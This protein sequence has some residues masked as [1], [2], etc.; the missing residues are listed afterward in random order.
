MLH[1]WKIPQARATMDIDL[2]GKLDNSVAYVEECIK[3][4]LQISTPD[5]GLTFDPDSVTSIDIAHDADYQGRRVLFFGYLERMRIRMKIDIGFSDIVLP[6]PILINFPTA[7]DMNPPILQGYTRESAIAEKFHAMV[8]LGIQNS[9]MKDF[10]DIYVLS[11]NYSF[12]GVH[13]SQALQGTFK[14][15]HTN[16][17]TSLIITSSSFLNMKDAQWAAF[18]KK[19]PSSHLSEIPVNLEKVVQRIASFLLPPC[20]ALQ[21]KKSFEQTWE[22][23]ADGWKS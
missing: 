17:P 8:F 7:L 11:M 9:R 21:T 16:I 22:P 12:K 2:L 19:F 23:S 13:L 3:K 14:R 4:I 6:E 20:I 1:V 5:D 18:F 15:R 10:Y